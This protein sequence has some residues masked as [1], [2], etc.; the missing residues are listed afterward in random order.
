M[1]DNSHPVTIRDIRIPFWRLVVIFIKMF[2]AMIPAM[3]A[4]YLIFAG[5]TLGAFFL[6]GGEDGFQQLM[7]RFGLA[8]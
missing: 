8:I 7:D 2:F 5:L 1:T 4:I 3:I 6:I